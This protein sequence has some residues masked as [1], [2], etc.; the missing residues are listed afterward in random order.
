[1]ELSLSLIHI[2]REHLESLENVQ[3]I[4]GDGSVYMWVIAFNNE[5]EIFSDKRVR[6][7]ISYAINRDEIVDGAL[8]GFGEAVEMPIVPSVF[9]Y[10]PEFK[11][12]EYDLEKAKQLMA[13]AGYAD[14]L[15]VTIKLNQP[16]TY[17]LSLIH[18]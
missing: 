11:G 12:H 14:G 1:M 9:G 10:D 5:S 18:I 3:F 8:N 6:E 7:A 13:E 16:S 17:T 4:A 2:Y 15:T